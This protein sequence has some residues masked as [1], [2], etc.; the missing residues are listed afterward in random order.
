MLNAINAGATP[1][2]SDGGGVDD[3]AG[4]DVNLSVSAL[5]AKSFMDFLNR[6]G[7]NRQAG[8]AENNRNFATDSGY[9][10]WL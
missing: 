3:N 5:D 9:G 7:L 4:G 2:F 6:G 8:A 1:E 10:K